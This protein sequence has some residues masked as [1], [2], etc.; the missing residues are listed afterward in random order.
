MVDIFYWLAAAVFCTSLIFAFW[1]AG[2]HSRFRLLKP[3][4]V[5]IGGVF[6]TAILL[7]YP[8]YYIRET[9]EAMQGLKALLFSIYSA[10]RLFAADAD[11]DMIL[12]NIGSIDLRSSYLTLA[13]VLTFVAPVMSISFVL[14]F[15]S[16]LSATVRYWWAFRRDTYV[17][18][19]LNER[20]LTL[21]EDL[22]RKHPGV[23][24]VFTNVADQEDADIADL[25]DRA[26]DLDA[27]CFRHEIQSVSFHF[28][29]K[30]KGLWFFAI[31]EDENENMHTALG[32]IQRYGDR[33]NTNLYV[34]TTGIESEAL[35]TSAQNKAMRVRRVDEVQS[36]INRVLYDQGHL[37]FAG[38]LPVEDGEKKITAVVV[39]MGKHGSAMIKALAWFCQLDGYRVHIH[40]FDRDPRA[41]ERFWASCPELMDKRFNGAFPAGDAH[42]AIRLH[43]GVQVDSKRF[44]DRMH[45]LKDASYVL[46]ALGDD[47]TNIRV[48]MELRVLFEQ[49]GAKPRIQAVLYSA[50]K[51]EALRDLRNFK[52]QPYNI[53]FIGDRESS[54]SADTILDSELEEDALRRHLRWGKESE[55]WGYEYNYRSSMALAIHSRAKQLVGIA[56]ANKADEDLTEAERL[57]LEDMEHRRWNAYMRSQ[58]YIYSGSPEKSSRNDLG[59]MHHDLIPYA[60]L[61][62]EEKRKDSRVASK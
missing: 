8:A 59:R 38:D 37:L 41:K 31:G 16:N 5:V 25:R 34:F 3:L 14:S 2:R 54:Y 60:D 21:A 32:L 1:L 26:K 15:F 28:H 11:Y 42:Y 13:S 22:H 52:G 4:N 51:A 61:T 6:L 29:A 23:T 10:M 35:L 62:E 58:G 20:S 47:E 36:L 50:E 57:A 24:L 53:E 49:C 7:F 27:I 18:S 43:P 40:G 44:V 56:G 48:A 39:G 17:F 19:A 55:F 45:S 12:D 9:D 33:A 30:D 46:V